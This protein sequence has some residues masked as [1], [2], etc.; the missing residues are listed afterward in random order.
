MQ[1]RLH[2]SMLMISASL[3]AMGWKMCPFVTIFA[4]VLMGIEGI[5]SE[6]E[7]PFGYDYSDLPLDFMAA[8]LRNE[9]NQ[10][11]FFRK[12]CRKFVLRWL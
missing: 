5:A 2:C 12:T 10:I 7:S 1:T 11:R 6:I 4:F 8:E 3:S 9:V